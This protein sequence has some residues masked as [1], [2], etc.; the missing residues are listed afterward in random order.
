MRSRDQRTKTGSSQTERFFTGPRTGPG[1]EKIET[2][3]RTRAEKI[4][5]IRDQHGPGPAKIEPSDRTGLGG[6]WMLDEVLLG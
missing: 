5:G 1:P 6:S 4:F 2:E 3:D